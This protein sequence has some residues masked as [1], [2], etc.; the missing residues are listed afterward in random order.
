M[1]TRLLIYRLGSLG[2]TL[3]ALPAFHLIRE[4]FPEARITLLTHL[5]AESKAPAIVSV[6]EHTNLHQGVIRYPLRLRSVRQIKALR[7]E[8]AAG[9]FQLAIHLAESRGTAKTLRDYVF[10]RACGI[11]RVVGLPWGRETLAADGTGQAEWEPRRLLRRLACL[12]KPNLEEEKWWDLRLR[13]EELERADK[14]LSPFRGPFLAA[15]LGTK[16]EVNHWTEGNWRSLLRQIHQRHPNLNLVLLGA[17]DEFAACER[18]SQDWTGPKLNLC[19]EV[20]PRVSAAILRRA[21]L[22]VG[23]DSGPLHLAATV[24]TPWVGIYSA[25]HWPGQ[26]FPRGRHNALLYHRTPCAGCGLDVCVEHG[27]KCI[28][29]ITVEEAMTAV[30]TQLSDGRGELGGRM[31]GGP[32]AAN[33]VTAA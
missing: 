9:Q 2:D 28:L 14:I 29:S 10:L 7:D 18:C 5:P 17:A 4:N 33:A 32:R 26:W 23:H 12:G 22:F 3:L 21:R 11:R 13:P 30:E 19:G 25:R 24:G 16:V 1:V 6:L 20:P 15:S 31:A 8:I 27:K